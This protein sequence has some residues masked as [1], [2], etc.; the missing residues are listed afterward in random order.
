MRRVLSV[1]AE[2]KSP[3]GSNQNGVVWVSKVN[4]TGRTTFLG[5]GISSY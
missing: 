2:V 3:R 1:E 4:Q 5:N